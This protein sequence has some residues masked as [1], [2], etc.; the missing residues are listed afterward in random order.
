MQAIPLTS[1]MLSYT[2]MA[3]FPSACMTNFSHSHEGYK[4][5][6]PKIV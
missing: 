4:N 3:E 2:N 1:T 6:H 5:A